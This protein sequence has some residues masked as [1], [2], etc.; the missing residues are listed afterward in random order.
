MGSA[1]D[2]LCNVVMAVLGAKLASKFRITAASWLLPYSYASIKE[3]C[4]QYGLR[5]CFK[6]GHSCVRKIVSYARWER[7]LVWRSVHRAWDIILK[8]SGCTC[9]VWSLNDA[10]ARLKRGLEHLCPNHSGRCHRCSSYSR[11]V[12]VSWLTQVNSSKSLVSPRRFVKPASCWMYSL[13]HMMMVMFLSYG[14]GRKEDGSVES[15]FCTQ[16]RGSRG[17]FLSC[18]VLS[19]QACLSASRPWALQFFSY[20]G[21]LSVVF[22]QKLPHASPWGDRSVDGKEVSRAGSLKALAPTSHGTMQ[23]FIFD[24]QMMW[25]S[26]A[27]CFAG[28]VLLI[29]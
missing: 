14:H 17:T 2:W 21:Y 13:K 22:F 29:S 8:S 7:K 5:V 26:L 19:S 16:G 6:K 18:C 20:L 24:S 10:S 11:V 15:A 3:K 12:L 25:F 1:N 27:R 23:F 28:T 4:W 9:D